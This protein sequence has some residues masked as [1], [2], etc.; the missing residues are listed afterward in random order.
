MKIGDKLSTIM[1]KGNFDA[2]FLGMLCKMESGK[3]QEIMLNETSIG[4]REISL[5]A[6][7]MNV[8]EYELV[9]QSDALCVGS[10]FIGKIVGILRSEGQ[11]PK[12]GILVNVG[13]HVSRPYWSKYS[14]THFLIGDKIKIITPR[15]LTHIIQAWHCCIYQSLE[16][17]CR[18]D[19]LAK[20]IGCGFKFCDTKLNCSHTNNKYFLELPRIGK[21][22]DKHTIKL[23]NELPPVPTKEINSL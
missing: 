14:R 21:H 13:A 23:N 6:A 8:D 16:N 3:I 2:Q 4:I 20:A 17:I 1:K 12:I 19:T 10:G 22:T 18:Y 15:C 5:L 11:K 9:T 7:A